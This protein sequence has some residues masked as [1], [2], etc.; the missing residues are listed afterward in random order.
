MVCLLWLWLLTKT[1][2]TI[3]IGARGHILTLDKQYIGNTITKKWKTKEK[4]HKIWNKS[5]YIFE[6]IFRVRFGPGLPNNFE[7]QP[8]VPN[9]GKLCQN[10]LIATCCFADWTSWAKCGHFVGIQ[11]SVLR[12]VFVNHL[13]SLRCCVLG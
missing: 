8:K 11:Y 9:L 10:P 13:C 2:N 4:H 3:L 6:H 12:F 1:C 7:P 5:S